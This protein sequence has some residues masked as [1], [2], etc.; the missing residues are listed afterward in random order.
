M[1]LKP[2]RETLLGELNAF[3][4]EASSKTYASG[5]K[6]TT[7]PDS[8][9][10]E[11]TYERGIWRYR[12]S[13][14]GSKRSAGTEVIWRLGKPLWYQHYG[15]GMEDRFSGNVNFVDDTFAFLKRA[16]L[17]GEKMLQFQPR[18][19]ISF[20]EGDWRYQSRL[21]EDISRFSGSEKITFLGG[22]VFTHKFFG[23]LFVSKRD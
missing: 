16:L 1:V 23:E 19:P 22:I 11:F 9:F 12:D 10:K 3:L 20:S 14:A 8:G 6:P 5:A 15:G 17:E 7:N 4:G 2:H 21:S 13:W 18:G